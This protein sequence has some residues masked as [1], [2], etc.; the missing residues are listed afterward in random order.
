VPD[1][2]TTDT[3]STDNKNRTTH[4]V[5]EADTIKTKEAPDFEGTYSL[6]KGHENNRVHMD[7]TNENYSCDEHFRKIYLSGRGRKP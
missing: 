7:V 6:V 4:M 2:N 1:T 5:V 3:N